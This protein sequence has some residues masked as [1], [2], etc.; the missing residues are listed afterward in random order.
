MGKVAFGGWALLRL[1]TGGYVWF[2]GYEEAGRTLSTVGVGSF[3]DPGSTTGEITSQLRSSL[4]PGETRRGPIRGP[5]AS[6]AR[7][8]MV[9]TRGGVRRS[10]GPRAFRGARR[11][12]SG[13]PKEY[14]L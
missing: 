13:K 7:V 6:V 2:P 4:R 14:E 3:R 12:G 1:P 10:Y 5:A 11:L 9:T 8:V